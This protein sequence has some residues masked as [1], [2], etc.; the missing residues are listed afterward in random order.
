MMTFCPYWNTMTDENG[1][2]DMT[3]GIS[4]CDES[5][6]NWCKN[7]FDYKWNTGKQ[8]ARLRQRV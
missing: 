4:G 3:M 6:V 8:F 1:I 7:F 2:T 5:F